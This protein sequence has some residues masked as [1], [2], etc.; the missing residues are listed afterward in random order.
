MKKKLTYLI[1]SIETFEIT[2]SSC[3]LKASEISGTNHEDI[4]PDPTDPNEDDGGL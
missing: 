2:E 1:P 4:T 3:L